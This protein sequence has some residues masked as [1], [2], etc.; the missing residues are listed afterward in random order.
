[1]KR[2]ILSGLAA[3]ALPA[4]ALAA[5]GDMS[6]AAFLTR[7]NALKEQG[8]MAL[9]SPDLT[10]L[11]SEGKA[12]GESYRSRL[13]NERATGRP[14]SCPPDNADIVPEELLTFLGSYPAK[15]R[16]HVSIRQGVADY[17]IKKYPCRNP[18]THT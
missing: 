1:M 18:V 16:P 6:V 13:I 12:A 17:F 15:V 2:M 9:F 11:K 10:L 5:P 3:L 7:A 4:A 14:S 8:P